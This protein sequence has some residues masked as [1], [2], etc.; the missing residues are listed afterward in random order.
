M[1][2]DT[3]ELLA[4]KQLFDA[5]DVSDEV[6]QGFHYRVKERSITAHGF[7]SIIKCVRPSEL[8]QSQKEISIS[9]THPQLKKGG[10]FVCWVEQDLTLCLE[11]FAA[12]RNW[13]LELLPHS[14][15]KSAP[16]RRA[17]K[18]SSVSRL[19]QRVPRLV[20][21]WVAQGYI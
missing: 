4:L 9:F 14:L 19:R 21:S 12:K 15:Q 11:G 5:S 2:L 8:I 10:M 16:I 3:I 6:T 13:P 7:F 20:C 18:D 17:A 1:H